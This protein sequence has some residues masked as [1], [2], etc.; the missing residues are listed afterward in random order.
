MRRRVLVV[1][2]ML[3]AGVLAGCGGAESVGEN[4]GTPVT[5]QSQSLATSCPSGYTETYLWQCARLDRYQPPCYY[6]GPGSYN[7]EHLY[8]QSGSAFYDAGPTGAYA[9]GDCF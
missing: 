1:G 2:S 4:P 6:A 7:V 8:C 9:C 5:E 3:V